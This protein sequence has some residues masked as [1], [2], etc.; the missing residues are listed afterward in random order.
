MVP[1]A[2]RVASTLTGAGPSG[3]VLGTAGGTTGPGCAAGWLGADGVASTFACAWPSGLV[4]G[5]GGTKAETPGTGKGAEAEVGDGVWAVSAEVSRVGAVLG[6]P[7]MERLVGVPPIPEG[8][9]GAPAKGRGIGTAPA[10]GAGAGLACGD[11]TA[12]VAAGSRAGGVPGLPGTGAAPECEAATLASPAEVDSRRPG[13]SAERGR[14]ALW[15]EPGLEGAAAARGSGDPV[16]ASPCPRS[17]DS[18]VASTIPGGAGGRRNWAISPENGL[19]E[20]S[21]P[22]AS[23]RSVAGRSATG[24]TETPLTCAMAASIPEHPDE[25]QPP[26]PCRGHWAETDQCSPGGPPARSAREVPPGPRRSCGEPA[27]TANSIRSLDPW[28]ATFPRARTG[29]PPAWHPG[30]PAG[31]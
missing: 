28:G 29:D 25:V 24:R 20:A 22:L 18:G 26:G 4:L 19:S 27:F 6:S 21:A 9:G 16:A 2:G 23:G 30:G 1:G 10:C 3:A 31:P 5:A 7:C 14:A 12:P 15:P 8:V 17:V 13:D 11:G